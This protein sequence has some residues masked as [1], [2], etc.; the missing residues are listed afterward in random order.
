MSNL[1]SYDIMYVLICVCVCMCV[2]VCVCVCVYLGAKYKFA[3]QWQIFCV[4]S[5][6]LYDSAERGYCLSESSY[7]VEEQQ[8]QGDG[9]GRGKEDR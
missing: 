7:S 9:N 1:L 8:Q 3:Q 2:C 5:Q 4:L 6:W